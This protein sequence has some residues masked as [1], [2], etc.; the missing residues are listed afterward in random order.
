[1]VRHAWLFAN[2][3]IE[4]SVEEED[5]G[6]LD[7]RQRQERIQSLRVEA[8]EEIWRKQGVDGIKA[9]LANTEAATTVG[10]GLPVIFPSDEPA[11]EFLSAP[12][13]ELRPSVSQRVDACLQGFLAHLPE[14][15]RER[16]L[17]AL[18][19]PRDADTRLLISSE[20]PF[21]PQ[22]TWRLVGQDSED[23]G[24]RY[25]QEVVPW[26]GRQHSDA[27]LAELLN[28]LLEVRRPRAAFDC[29][30]LDWDRLDTSRLKQLLSDVGTVAAEPSGT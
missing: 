22:A 30:H 3:W 20:P 5:Q 19:S 7:F 13:I 21:F 24:L 15:R 29:L 25:R 1:M 14:D 27:E 4:L 28:R 18:C 26:W 9:L 11:L 12:L 10:Q 16:V 6:D 17:T 8:L 23:V 2:Q